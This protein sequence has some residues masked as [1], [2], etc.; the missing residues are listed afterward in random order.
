[1]TGVECNEVFEQLQEYFDEETRTRIC[2][3]IEEHLHRCPTCQVYVDTVRKT[4]VL[5]QNDRHVEMPA[6][7][8]MQLEA[9]M[10]REYRGGNG[11]SD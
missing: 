6:H 5:Y 8:T 9:V 1:M 10:A 3:V 4:I 7:L 2:A 11:P